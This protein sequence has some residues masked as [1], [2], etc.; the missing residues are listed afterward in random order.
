MVMIDDILRS[1]RLAFEGA[2]NLAQTIR[3]R[4][5][6]ISMRSAAASVRGGIRLVL[7]IV[8]YALVLLLLVVLAGYIILNSDRDVAYRYAEPGSKACNDQNEIMPP[9]TMNTRPFESGE[10]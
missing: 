9:T 10:A 4:I 2:L 7:R 3:H 6:L 1:F 8:G 5:P